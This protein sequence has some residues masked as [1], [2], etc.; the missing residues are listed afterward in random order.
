MRIDGHDVRHLTAGSSTAAVG[1]V[2]QD[3]HMVEACR[4]DRIHDLV[5]GLPD[6]YETL[7][8]ERG[9]RLS[10]GGKQRRALARVLPAGCTRSSTP[11]STPG[12]RRGD[13]C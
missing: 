5:S 13:A 8:G 9:Y 12:P 11:P 10:G 4:A 3:A 1:M 6:G 2:T 7:V